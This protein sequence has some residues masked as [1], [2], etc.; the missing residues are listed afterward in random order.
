MAR[1]PGYSNTSQTPQS[2]LNDSVDQS[3][4]QLAVEILGEDQAGGA[5]R[6][7][8]VD[9]SGN[10]KTLSAPAVGGALDVTLKDL[11][12]KLSFL[13]DRLEYGLITDN[14]K[15]LYVNAKTLPAITIAAA[16]TLAT[17]TTVSSVTNTVRQGDLQTQRL[18]EA[19]LD[20]AFINGITNNLA[21]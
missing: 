2:I 6:R 5:L 14:A 17:V 16:Q 21:F 18:N 4:N 10:L 15:V 8:Q 13:E 12:N 20:A 3:Y 7:L 11:D 1:N 9:S 19:I